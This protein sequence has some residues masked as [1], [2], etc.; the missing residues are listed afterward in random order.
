MCSYATL[1]FGSVLCTEP[2]QTTWSI[3]EAIVL[4]RGPAV[5]GGMLHPCFLRHGSAGTES[6]EGKP[7]DGH[8]R[9]DRKTT[10][11]EEG[12]Q[13]ACKRKGISLPT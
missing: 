2:R 4:D 5:P 9:G 6:A 1:L 11:S 10:R 13:K 12:F 8:P 7:R 3:V